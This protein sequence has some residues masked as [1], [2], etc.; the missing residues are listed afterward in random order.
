M[1]SSKVQIGYKSNKSISNIVTSEP[2]IEPICT[3]QY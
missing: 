2:D 1:F 3:L